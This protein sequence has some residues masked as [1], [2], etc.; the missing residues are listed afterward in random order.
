MKTGIRHGASL[1]WLG[2][3]VAAAAVILGAWLSADWTPRDAKIQGRRSISADM[4][5]RKVAILGATTPVGLELYHMLSLSPLVREIVVLHPV[6][7]RMQT[8]LSEEVWK[9]WSPKSMVVAVD[10]TNHQAIADA[11]K[12][13]ITLYWGAGE[14]KHAPAIT[15]AASKAGVEHVSVVTSSVWGAKRSQAIRD[16]EHTLRHA[17]LSR[18]SIFRPRLLLVSEKGHN[19]V[20]MQAAAQ[21]S[22]DQLLFPELSGTPGINNAMRMIASIA[23]NLVGK[24]GQLLA[25][26]GVLPPGWHPCPVE[27]VAR[28]MWVQSCWAAIGTVEVYESPAILAVASSVPAEMSAR[29]EQAVADRGQ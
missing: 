12:G 16:T 23:H 8:E 29:W 6:A 14:Q 18:V 11:L 13:V 7:S 9:H 21:E 27:S 4:A 2:V 3:C 15:A 10:F 1:P 19:S 5:P 28:T 24:A 25:S 26:V 17:Q 20:Q 22:L